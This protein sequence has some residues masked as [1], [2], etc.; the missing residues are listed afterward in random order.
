MPLNPST[1]ARKTKISE[2]MVIVHKKD[3]EMIHPIGNT[4]S[5]H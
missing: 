4:T 1:S 2:G 5:A 3:S